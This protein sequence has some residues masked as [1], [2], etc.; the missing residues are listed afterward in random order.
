MRMKPI[1]S[2]ASG[3]QKHVLS[4]RRR[5]LAPFLFL[6]IVVI[7]IKIPYSLGIRFANFE[8][9]AAKEKFDIVI[10]AVHF[11][12]FA[13]YSRRLSV[14]QLADSRGGILGEIRISDNRS[15]PIDTEMKQLTKRQH[16][17]RR[18]GVK[19]YARCVANLLKYSRKHPW[20]IFRRRVVRGHFPHPQNGSTQ[21]E[22]FR[23][24][25]ESGFKRTKWQLILPGQTAG[26]VKKITPGTEGADQYHIRFYD[27]GTID[28]EAEYNRFTIRHWSGVMQ[29]GRTVFE[30][31]LAELPIPE[32]KRAEIGMLF[33]DAP[34]CELSATEQK[35]A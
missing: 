5:N 25:L 1:R 20:G 12:F 2:V 7:F 17:K 26:V 22:F 14:R 28:C 15:F 31:I 11:D 6:K 33:R 3:R 35:T 18:A 29:K 27:D 21:K 32:N 34:P 16:V 4:G 10:G 8:L 9:N 30:R 23:F 24:L 19:T 13:Q